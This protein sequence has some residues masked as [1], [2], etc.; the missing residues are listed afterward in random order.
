MRD[1]VFSKE[2]ATQRSP[3]PAAIAAGPSPVVTTS[4]ACSSAG[5]TR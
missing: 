4:V 1:T 3:K 5:S 2:S